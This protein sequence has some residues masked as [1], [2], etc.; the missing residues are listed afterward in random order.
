MKRKPILKSKVAPFIRT[1]CKEISNEAPILI[2]YEPIPGKKLK[3]CFSI[4]PE[5]V[6][7]DG[8]K[9]TIGWHIHVW[10]RVWIEAEFHCVWEDILGR[11]VDVTPKLEKIN[12]TIF[13]P[14]PDIKYTGRQIDNIRKPLSTDPDIAVLIGLYSDQFRHMNQGDL[15]DKYGPVAELGDETFRKRWLDIDNMVL[16]AESKII[17]KYHRN[18]AWPDRPRFPNQP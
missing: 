1:F 15:A 12:Y 14:A 6:I 8:G 4:V 5:K 9:Q 7:L 16:E 17:R 10:K 3:E 13:L 2:P 11:I 18:P